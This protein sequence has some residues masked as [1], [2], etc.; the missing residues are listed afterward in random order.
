MPRR[1][2]DLV[3]KLA[4][5]RQ[6]VEPRLESAERGQLSDCHVRESFVRNIERFVDDPRDQLAGAGTGD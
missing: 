4:R 2:R 6:P 1:N 5:E 3:G